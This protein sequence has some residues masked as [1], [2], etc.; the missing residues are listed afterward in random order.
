MGLD[1][2]E[3]VIDVEEAFDIRISDE[4]AEQ[5]LTVGNLYDVILKMAPS[6][7]TPNSVCLSA[8]TFRLIRRSLCDD[9]HLDAVRLR[10][11]DSIESSFPRLE[12]RRLWRELQESLDLRLPTLVRPFWLVLLLTLIACTCA[13]AVGIYS[14]R[15]IGIAFPV[16]LATAI[17]VGF[18]L[19]TLS[20]PSA[21][22]FSSS[23]TTYRDLTNA[24]ITRNY[25][26]LATRLEAWDSTDVWNVL[27]EIIVERLGVKPESVTRD[28]SF[29]EDLGLS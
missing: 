3:L 8:G 22:C 2:V 5:I 14:S 4:R 9:L 26:V 6:N 13:I 17:G 12:R 27:K 1:A 28:A 16:G 18:V 19:T 23:L 24:A 7:N 10:P 21:K 15:R 20:R 29:V 11:G 25:A